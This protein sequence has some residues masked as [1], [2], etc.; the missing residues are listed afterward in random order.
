LLAELPTAVRPAAEVLSVFVAEGHR[1]EGVGS[2]L[3]GSIEHVLTASGVS[4]VVAVYMTGK[5]GTA[6]LERI[7]TRCG[8]SVPVVRKL[9]VQCTPEQATRTD[10]YPDAQL[11]EG[12]ELFPWD[13]LRDA[14][15]DSL[16]QSQDESPWIP[17]IL[18]PWAC[19]PTFDRL[20]SVGM[21]LGGCVVGWVL[22]H[23]AAPDLVRFT[24]CFVRADLQRRGGLFPLLVA[25]ID[26]L[27]GTGV[28]CT[29]VTTD[30]FPAMVRF[31]RRRLA[32]FVTYCGESRGV[33]KRLIVP[34]PQQGLAP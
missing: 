32:P 22:T 30:R 20:S 33:S 6:A 16:R 7:F 2:A 13:E 19:G 26:R 8:Y 17:D 23:R 25:S 14:E 15:M 9:I 1:G 18:Q 28:T 21:R 12:A 24:A 4:D 10:W 3:F 29:F 27:L 11:P 34:A 5:P 31:T